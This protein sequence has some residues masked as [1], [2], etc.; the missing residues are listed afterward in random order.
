MKIQVLYIKS[1]DGCQLN[2]SHCF[3]SG[4]KHKDKFNHTDTIEWLKKLKRDDILTPDF[5]FIWI[6]G[7]PMTGDISAMTEVNE[8]VKENYPE[9]II[10]M[11]SNLTYQLTSEK[12]D[13]LNQLHSL[14]TSWDVDI[15]FETSGQKELWEQNVKEISPKFDE[16]LVNVCI[17]NKLLQQDPEELL[18]KFIGL[19]FK[20]LRLTRL[21]NE[22]NTKEN[23]NIVPNYEQVDEWLCKFAKVYISGYH[24]QIREDLIGSIIDNHSNNNNGS[25]FC[26]VCEQTILSV[27]A[28][29]TISSCINKGNYNIFGDIHQEPLEMMSSDTRKNSIV[30][31]V[32]RDVKCLSCELYSLCNGDCHNLEWQGDTCPAPKETMKFIKTIDTHKIKKEQNGSCVK[33]K[34]SMQF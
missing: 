32:N 30:C 6:G 1:A 8:W 10:T 15:R 20:H 13:F 24:T 4:N 17:D 25:T 7:E 34:R 5:K 9:C 22:G 26:R 27:N 3:S 18:N 2:C 23:P 12:I 21:S 29:G 11:T 33:T 31:E 14:S 19:G 16:L 28:N